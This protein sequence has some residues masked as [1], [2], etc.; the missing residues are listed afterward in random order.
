MHRL[1]DGST[2]AG[3]DTAAVTGQSAIEIAAAVRAGRRT[4]GEVVDACLSRIAA[5]DSRI[6]AFQCVVADQA[7]RA[8]AELAQRPD[9]AALPLAGVPVAVKDNIAV[10]GLPTRHGSAATPRTTETADD[11]LVRRLRA[12]GAIVVGKTRMPE[13]AIWGFTESRAHGGTRNPHD[14]TRNAGGSTGGGA[15]A[16]AAGMVPL[17]LGSDGGGSLR[18]PAANCGVVGLKPTRGA[19]PL[20]GGVADH[21]Y[22]CTAFGPIAA[23]VADVALVLDILAGA[24]PSARRL[25]APTG[26]LRVAVS[27][28][29]ASPLGPPD[30]TA[31]AAVDLAARLVEAAGHEVVRAHP[32]Y[33]AT[34][35]NVWARHWLAGVAEE[36]DRLALPMAALEPRTRSV[37]NRGRRLRR[38]SLPAAGPADRWRAQARDWFAGFDALLT[39]VVARPAPAAG[40]A[41]DIGYLRTYLGAARSI[42]FTQPWNLAGFPALSLPL[43]GTATRCGAIQLVT[44]P[45]NE[46]TLLNL[47]AQLEHA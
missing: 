33:P 44:A 24:D 41:T 15:A 22:G 6:G 16:V 2:V 36:A 8:A 9:L 10:A 28:R 27:L 7:R 39:P 29:P 35:I 46:A 30:A 19:V 12:A 13:L 43:G 38:R 1:P 47:A 40:A 25:D 20:A 45:G 11:E 18:I 32:P 26:R 34:V 3:M 21:W 42:S 4:P 17:A 37:V 14:L 5:E 23:T 31:R